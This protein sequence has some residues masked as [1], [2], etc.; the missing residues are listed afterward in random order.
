MDKDL[1]FNNIY[2]LFDNLDNFMI[3]SN[4][5]KIENVNALGRLSLYILLFIIIFNY[6]TKYMSIPILLM[7][8]SLFLGMTLH[9][10]SMDKYLNIVNS[11]DSC[12]NPTLNNPFMNFTIGDLIE[13]PN[14]NKACLYDDVKDDMRKEFRNN[15]NVDI[16]DIWGNYI[17]DR[18]FYTMP[19]TDIVN[20]QMGFAKW[21]YGDL[22][23]CKTSGN[24]CI[25]Y[26]DLKY[27]KGR[28]TKE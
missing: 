4:N 24:D 3:S 7:L 18:N 17:S 25:I 28:F 22:G 20:D 21:C 5:N 19:N 27:H 16:N 9:L 26:R 11:N 13:N 10:K 2:V 8:I 6:D 23:K 12:Q 1:W 15:I 14:R